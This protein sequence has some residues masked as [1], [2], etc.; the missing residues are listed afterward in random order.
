LAASVYDLAIIGAGVMG[1]FTAEFARRRGAT[2]LLV[3]Q[4]RVGDPRAA[5]FSLTRSIRNDY[6]DPVYARLAFEARKLWLDFQRQT[7]ESFLVECGCLN[8]AKASVTSALSE[9]YAE[10][11]YRVLEGLHLKTQ[12]FTRDGLRARFPQFDA[13]LGR[14]DVQAGLLY[15]PPITQAL[16]AGLRAA[17]VAIEQHTPVER[18]SRRHGRIVIETPLGERVAERLVVTAGLGTNDLLGRTEGC[19]LRLPLRPDRPSESKYFIPPPAKR[20]HFMP[21]RLPVFAYLDVGIYGHP[22]LDGKTPG[23]KIGYYNPPDVR[24]QETRITNV[25]SFVAECMPELADARVVDVEGADQCSY[26]LVA[27]DDFIL[28]RIPGF[29]G[30]AVGTGWRGTGYKFAPLI[31]RT[32]MELTLDNATIEDIARFAPERFSVSHAC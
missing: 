21:G 7:G 10:Q 22:M 11:S 1:L 3:D 20:D 8:I 28:G 13:D 32:L 18:I 5:S 17:R 26:D 12:A 31:G 15:V 29:P 27:D 2:V 14:L 6:L 16:L 19:D 25:Q 9:T 4:W 30:G 23:V 24:R